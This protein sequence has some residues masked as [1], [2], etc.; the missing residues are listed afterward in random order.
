MDEHPD[1]LGYS[2]PRVGKTFAIELKDLDNQL[3]NPYEDCLIFAPKQE[4]AENSFSEQYERIER[5]GPIKS[6]IRRN[7]AGKIEL[8][9]NGVQF[10]NHSKTKC[11]GINSNFEGENASILRIEELDDIP[12]NQ[13]KRVMGRGIGKN[14]NGL[15]TRHRLSGVIWGKL[16]IWKYQNDPIYFT[17]PT[18]DAYQGLAAGLLEDAAVRIA[19]SE[20]SDDEW[21]RTMCLKFIESRNFIWSSWL[22]ASQYIGLKWDLAPI[23]PMPEALNK[24]GKITF[25]LDMGAQGSGED[26]SEYSLQVI[27][28]SG[29][30]RRWL[31]GKTWPSDTDPETLI[32]EINEFWAFYQPDMAYSDA[33]DAN[34]AVQVNEELYSKGLTFWDWKRL[35]D[36][37]QEGW[38][39]WAERGLMTPIHNTSRNKHAMYVSLRNAINN[40][41]TLSKLSQPA[42]TIFVFPQIDRDKAAKLHGWKELQM[43]IRELENLVAEILP[44]G[45]YKIERYKKKIEDKQLK[46]SGTIKLGDDR[47]DALAM[48]NWAMDFVSG[49]NKQVFIKADYLRG[50]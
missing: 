22:K 20:M 31:Y 1:I 28:G 19:R 8:S 11:F 44:S 7:A 6:F 9:K 17:L 29:P 4:Q 45:L 41:V 16:N 2:A 49:K 35:G 39:R 40:C 26:A 50:F 15:P 32:K 13:I 5:E 37:N 42:G 33:R 34:L 47:T 18:V 24:H 38:N 36:N 43:L 14:K 12:D 25:G 30:F 10:F 48:A 27:E 23:P 21:L 3:M 46:F